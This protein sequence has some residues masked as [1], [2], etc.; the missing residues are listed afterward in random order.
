MLDERA[1]R[2]FKLSDCNTRKLQKY[3]SALRKV[4]DRYVSLFGKKRL[5]VQRGGFL[6]PLLSAIV[7]TIASFMFRLR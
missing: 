7:P 5:I 4:A 2:Q 6:L 1:K 3:K